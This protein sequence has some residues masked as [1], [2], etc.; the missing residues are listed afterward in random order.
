MGLFGFGKKKE[1]A[2]C[3]LCGAEIGFLSG[4][5]LKDGSTICNGCESKLRLKYDEAVVNKT[6]ALGNV[7]FKDNGYAKTTIV[8]DLSAI[9]LD[10]ARA[11]MDEINATSQALVGEIGGSYSNIFTAGKSGFVIA[12]K[13]LDVGLPR[14]KKLK[15][16]TVVDGLVVEGEFNKDQDAVLIINGKEINV[17]IIE[18]HKKDV[19]AFETT[20]SANLKQGIKKGENGYLIISTEESVPDGATIAK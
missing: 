14:S 6:D 15:N 8:D 4:K 3:P 7:Q 10:E 18:A 17:H 2:K 16:A 13:A 12:P 19:S 20:L 11:A 1:K 5:V 9:T